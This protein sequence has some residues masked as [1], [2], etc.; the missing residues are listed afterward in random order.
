MKKPAEA[1]SVGYSL[2]DEIGRFRW[3]GFDEC[4]VAGQYKGC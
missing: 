2:P 3:A 1:G 4:F